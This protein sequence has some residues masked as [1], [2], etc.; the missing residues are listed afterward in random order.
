M[1]YLY[2]ILWKDHSRAHL[3]WAFLGTLA[4]FVLL[5]SGTPAWA[6]R[7]GF[8]SGEWGWHP[9]WGMWGIGMGIMMLLFWAAIIVGIIAL[10]RWVW[11]QGKGESFGML[12][13]LNWRSHG[14]KMQRRMIGLC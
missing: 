11:G 14:T 13:G 1:R 2:S 10:V 5:L 6:Q 4:G 7:G 8:G 3:L 12:L 9:M